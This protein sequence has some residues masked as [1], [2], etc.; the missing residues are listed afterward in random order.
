MP[1]CLARLGRALASSR[2]AELCSPC[3]NTANVQ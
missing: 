1:L 2:R 3:Y